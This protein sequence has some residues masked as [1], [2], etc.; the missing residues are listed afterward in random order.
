MKTIVWAIF[1]L[2]GVTGWTQEVQPVLVRAAEEYRIGRFDSVFCLLSNDSVKWEREEKV[3]AFR[4]MALAC[5]ATDKIAESRDMVGK[6]LKIEPYYTPALNDPQGFLKLVKDMQSGKETLV[7]ASQQAEILEEA[8]VPVT[9]I[10][11]EMLCNIGARTLKDALIAYV[12]GFTSVESPDDMNVAMHGVYSSAQQKV[13]IMLNGHRLNSRS[14]NV[15]NPDYSISLDKIKQI[16]VLRGPASSLYGNVALTA[17]VNMITRTGMEVDGVETSIGMGSFGQKKAALLLGKHFINTDFMVWGNIYYSKGE[18]IVVPY[19]ESA[20]NHGYSHDGY[21]LSGSFR[22]KP[23]YDLGF[24]YRWNHFSV[25]FSNRYA[26]MASQYTLYGSTYTYDKYRDFDGEK[27]G[28][29]YG[30]LH[31]EVAWQNNAGAYQFDISAYADHATHNLYSVAGD[32]IIYESAYGN[33]GASQVIRWKELTYGGM[34]K[35]ARDYSFLVGR[36]HW[37]AGLQVEQM[38]VNRMT[39]IMSVKYDSVFMFF[40]P[41]ENVLQTGKETGVSAFLQMKHYFCEELILNAGVRMDHKIRNDNRKMTAFSPR[42]SLIWLPSGSWSIKAGFSR[43]F[44]DAP[45][46]Y[47]NN[48][49]TSYKGGSGLNP[50]TMD[51]VQFTVGWQPEKNG[52]QINYNFFYNRMKDFVYHPKEATGDQSR[53][54]NAGRLN[55]TGIECTAVYNCAKIRTDFNITWQHVLNG[56]DYD[57]RDSKVYNVPSFFANLIL[58]VP[59][60]QQREH[61]LGVKTFFSFTGRQLSPVDEIYLAGQKVELPDN[62][63]SSRCIANVGVSYGWKRVN[64]TGWCYHLLDNHYYQGGTGLTPYRQPGRSFMGCLSYVFR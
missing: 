51:A 34:L 12:P 58:A 21:S 28:A 11:R 44:V 43:S 19:S 41:R 33:V 4:L 39:S 42:I 10:T 48:I 15:A 24:T 54:I 64:V 13:L 63:V 32:S 27:P 23:A 57:F 26:K 1:L 38:K 40:T 14:F 45:Y 56:N 52:F 35:V 36:G 3:Q 60:W 31:T 62:T 18:K 22:D 46:F 55:I 30:S 6:M 16:E 25:L 37:L 20:D 53:Y 8:P 59:L 49:A 5:L 47:R 50:E 61:R 7:T 9:L 2:V 17:V 29:G